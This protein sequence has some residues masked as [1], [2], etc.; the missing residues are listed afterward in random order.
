MSETDGSAASTQPC[1]SPETRQLDFWVGDWDC[2][3]GENGVGSNSIRAVLDGCVI[4]ENFDANPTADF[5]GRSLSMYNAVLGRWEQTWVDN[6]GN[7]W[8]LTG[9]MQD[10]R[11]VLGCDEV[12]TAAKLRMVFFDIEPDRFEW[13]WERS[14]DEGRTWTTTWQ[15]HYR[16]KATPAG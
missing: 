8:A 11:M 13:V 5:R 16:R 1:S 10:G 15:I 7:Y 3:W 12:G 6:A 4:E 9:G 14:E 2:T